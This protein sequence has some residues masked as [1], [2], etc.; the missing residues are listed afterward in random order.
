MKRKTY[1]KPVIS[2]VAILHHES[3]LAGSG[4]QNHSGPQASFMS[5]PGIGDD[6][7]KRADEE[8]EE[9]INS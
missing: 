4:G 6:E 1:E 3:L 8:D 7:G 2:A 9:D 5:D